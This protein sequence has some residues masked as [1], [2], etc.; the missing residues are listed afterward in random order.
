MSVRRQALAYTAPR[1]GL[2]RHER[3]GPFRQNS[4]LI[5]YERAEL[6]KATRHSA[7]DSCEP[8]RRERDLPLDRASG[9]PWRSMRMAASFSRSSCG[10]SY[11]AGPRTALTIEH[12]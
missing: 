1:S 9:R 10:S 5:C 2:R 3:G 12:L 6:T 4:W 11:S 7:H 8:A